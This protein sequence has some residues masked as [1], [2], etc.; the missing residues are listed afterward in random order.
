M[1][2]YGGHDCKRNLASFS[3]FQHMIVYVKKHFLLAKHTFYSNGQVSS[4]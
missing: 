2:K 3:V 1:D 4:P